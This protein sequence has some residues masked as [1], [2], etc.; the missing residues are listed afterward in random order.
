MSIDRYE[1]HETVS[2]AASAE[3]EF[4]RRV[5]VDFSTP[6]ISLKSLTL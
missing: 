2:K 3:R 5:Q 4:T 6:T 1:F